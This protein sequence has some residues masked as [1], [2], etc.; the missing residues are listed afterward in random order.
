MMFSYTN[1]KI[2][3]REERRMTP[4]EFRT[5][6][7]HVIGWIRK[8]LEAH[9]KQA[10]AVCSL[11][12]P[13]LSRY[14]GAGLLTSTKVVVVER[15]PMPPLSSLG[16]SRFAEF[17]RGDYDGITYLDTVFVKRR[18]AAAEQLHFH[19][20]IHVLQWQLLGPEAFL[21]TYAA[22]LEAFG[23]RDS[24]LEIMAYDAE[25]A[26]C[27]SEQIFDAEKLVAEKLS[28]MRNSI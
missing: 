14:F 15:V 5:L 27:Q 28:R 2:I 1:S 6:Y 19:E 10:K 20:L 9:S 17:E 21:A 3:G 25:L 16:L 13:R 18:S 4:E 24:P 7:P 11:G 23:Y 26:F 12:F 8:T 22:G